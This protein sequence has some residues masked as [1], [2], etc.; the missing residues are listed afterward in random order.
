MAFKWH[1]L[2][3]IP[4]GTSIDFIRLRYFT[5]IVSILITII[6]FAMLWAQ[7]LNLGIDFKGGILIEV[8][9]KGPANLKDL[10]DHVAHLGLGE[11]ALQEFG[12]SDEVLIRLARQEGG[13]QGQIQAI[14][15]IQKALGADVS[16]RRI[17]TVGP[18]MGEELVHNGIYAVFWCL[19]AMLVYIWIRF[20]LHFGICAIIALFHDAI[21]VLAL[22]TIFHF[23]FN[24]QA[25]VAI[26]MTVGYS[27]N[28]T[29]VI[30]DRIRENLRK[31]KTMSDRDLI[32]L[33]INETLSRTILTSSTTLLSLIALYVF[34]GEVVAE[35]SLPLIIGIVFGTYSSI[36]LSA[37]LLLF[38]SLRKK[39]Q[40]TEKIP[41]KA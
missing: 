12:R 27:I 19:V 31:Y 3:L 8:Q 25:I 34:G 14:S 35:Y 1:G 39:N 28:D 30:Y 18:K 23:E 16:F 21:A 33:S 22:Y 13:E 37:P 41:Q 17:E 36:F 7:G 9:T 5:Y 2:S 20:E 40:S 11:V 10:R 4:H 29:V 38:F 6:T 24:S 26:L 32:N 15:K